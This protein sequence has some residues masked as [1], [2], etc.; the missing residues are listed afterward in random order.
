MQQLSTTERSL[1]EGIDAAAMLA[2]VEQWCAI[3][4]GTGNL[5]GLAAQW[6]LLAD[7]FAALPG[8]VRKID[9]APVTAIAADGRE[10]ETVNGAHLVLSVRPQAPRRY[11]LTGHM[12]TVFAPA[13]P[14]QSLRWLDAETLNGPGVAD[15]KGGIAVILAALQAFESSP[16]SAGVGYDVMINSDEETGSLSSAPLIA[17]LARGKAA[18]LT[19]EPSALPDGTLAGERPGS[20]NFSAV[21]KGRSAHAG[22]NPQD[23]RN[24][25]IAA[26]DMALRLKALERPGLSINPA[27]I[28]GG[29]A[30]NVVPDLAVLRFNVRPRLPEL[31]ADLP[32]T[33]QDLALTL[34]NL[35]EVSIHLHG[36]ISRPPKPLTPQAEALFGL[37]RECGELLGQPIRW[38]ASGG[39][40][41]GNN[42]AACGVPVVDTMGVRG[43]AIHSDQEFLIVPSLAERAALSALVLHRL[44][45][46]NQ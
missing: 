8:E 25:I 27:R 4:T 33:L 20:A 18:A 23:G 39:V 45:G 10:L 26:A 12:D 9:P 43:G 28:D 44:S 21:I 16:M 42:I 14:F 30:N 19:Y 36:G 13:H 35:H 2:Q 5:A 34:E 24:A 7:A 41:D 22:R 6:S 1:I 32:Q 46:G 38:Q 11:L 15:M 3:N 31:A 17:E 40:C 37:V 29:S